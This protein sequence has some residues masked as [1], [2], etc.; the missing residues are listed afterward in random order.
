MQGPR[1]KEWGMKRIAR[2][3][4]IGILALVLGPAA[5]ADWDHPVKWDQLEP[6]AGLWGM[7]SYI[8]GEDN[9]L[10]ADDFQ[11]SETGWIT[12]IEFNGWTV[13]GAVGIES[14]RITFWSDVP[15]T[16]NEA[17]HPGEEPLATIT[18][19]EVDPSDTFGLGWQKLDEYTYKINLP[20][21]VWFRQKEGEIYWIGIQAVMGGTGS[22]NWIFR[23]RNACMW[24]DDAVYSPTGS[25]P[26]QHFGWPDAGPDGE[27]APYD[28][29]LPDDWDKSADMSFSLSG[30]PIPEPASIALVALGGLAFAFRRKR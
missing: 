5:L 9:V 18:V 14:F 2:S 24:N 28:M 11:C 12:D 10:V 8:G 21:D 25:A 23:D 15:E 7:V 17:S 16:F 1:E 26:W 6:D 20:K 22:F 30:I 27:P 19:G 13:V 3:F 4:L 29:K